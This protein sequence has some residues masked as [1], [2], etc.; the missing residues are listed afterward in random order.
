[1]N[2]VKFTFISFS[3]GNGTVRIKMRKYR[4]CLT[5]KR[6]GLFV[7]V[8]GGE[9]WA[10]EVFALKCSVAAAE[11]KTAGVGSPVSLSQN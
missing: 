7:L 9:G 5:M 10:G 3:L 2:A 1:M 6:K 11:K 8:Y 4:Q